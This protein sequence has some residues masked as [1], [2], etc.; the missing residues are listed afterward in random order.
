M[1]ASVMST[2]EGSGKWAE[3]QSVEPRLAGF[4]SL[5]EAREGWRRRDERC[6][7]VVAG[8]TALGSRRGGDDDDAALAVAVLLEE[9][10]NRVAMTLSD[11]CELVDVNT[12]VWEEVKAAEPSLGT[13]A[14]RYMLQRARQR[15]TRPA[16]GMV[17][18]V[19]A[20]SLDQRLGWD[21]P[22]TAFGEDQDRDLLLAVP[23][24][25]DPVE[26]L[27][28]LLTWAREIGVIAS[29]EIDL[30]VELLAAENDGMAREEAQRAVGERHGV[31]MRT[32]RRRRDRTAA[33]LRD[34]APQYLAAIA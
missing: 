25:E 9:G 32:I 20:T 22:A 5:E 31:A 29:E 30:L 2:L 4:A 28:D 34:A 18:R 8:L 10:V 24:V 7:Q 6:Y 23:E 12:T 1:A 27:A 16:A 17:A 11:V 26:D 15:L 33:R 21:R 19:Q 3:W 14:A 13:H